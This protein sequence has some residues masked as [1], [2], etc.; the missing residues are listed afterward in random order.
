[1][2]SILADYEQMMTKSGHE[3]PV[4]LQ[5]IWHR[6]FNSFKETIEVKQASARSW[7]L[8]GGGKKGKS[9][10]GAMGRQQYNLS[11]YFPNQNEYDKSLL[12]FMF[13]ESHE[14]DAWDIFSRFMYK[15]HLE[16]GVQEHDKTKY[17]KT[18]N[19]L[20]QDGEHRVDYG[21][22]E[23][24][25]LSGI[26]RLYINEASYNIKGSSLPQGYQQIMSRMQ[27]V[28][29]A[30]RFTQTEFTFLG[31]K[32]REGNASIIRV[33]SASTREQITSA[34]TERGAMYYRLEGTDPNSQTMADLM[35][36]FDSRLKSLVDLVRRSTEFKKNLR[37][38][39]TDDVAGIAR[40]VTNAV[41]SM[42]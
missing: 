4:E 8:Y 15:S 12:S 2:G 16:H 36:V 40:D 24:K 42:L 32:I 10:F 41:L 13:I 14:R 21:D 7:D 5:E 29:R 30:K 38:G 34:V 9:Y 1:W 3:L 22:F 18:M 35:E 17:E 28:V 31:S 25:I 23:A 19:N 26:K 37:L 27:E 6:Y 11:D 33:S 20:I 39:K